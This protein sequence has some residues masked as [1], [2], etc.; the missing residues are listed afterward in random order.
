[1]AVLS[2]REYGRIRC[3]E[4]F[5]PERQTVTP[6][7]RHRL[8]RFS[9][10]YKVQHKVAVLQ[11]G[12]HQSLVAQNFVGVI[13]LGRDQ[14]EVLPK[15]DGLEGNDAQVRQN[16]AAMIARTYDLTLR[17][18]DA[19]KMN[20]PSESILEILIRLFCKQ[21]WL[22]VHKGM[23]RSYEHRSAT[24]NVL[25]GRLSVERQIRENSVRPD[26]LA[27]DFDEFSENNE[28]NK[29]LKAALRVLS[30]VTRSTSNHRNVSELLFCFSEVDDVTADTLRWAQDTSNRT[31]ARYGKLLSLARLFLRDQAPDVISGDG[32]GFALLFDMNELFEKYIG[33]LVQGIFSTSELHVRLQRPTRH[34]ARRMDGASSF[35]LRP[36]IVGCQ[37][38][39][40]AWIVDTKWK[41]LDTLRHRDGVSSADMYQMHAYARRYESP[42]VYL[43]Y[44]HHNALGPHAGRRAGY[45]LEAA[46]PNAPLQQVSVG[47]VDLSDLSK[48]ASQLTEILRN[49]DAA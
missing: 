47:T 20:H 13:N 6:S 39:Q 49:G 43:L 44:P 7:Q 24:L 30:R 11:Y 22:E 19:S 40:I 38:D 18:G 9:E 25:R 17:D 12:P 45:R 16:L 21:L 34:L 33:R 10:G 14:V 23:L 35:E 4:T 26:L 15:I 31:W 1:M 32:D 28:L 42:H 48:V 8:E 2:V 5:D 29:T 3:G 41:R 36:D 37:G 46:F 27:C